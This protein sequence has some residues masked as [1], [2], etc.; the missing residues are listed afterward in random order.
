[1]QEFFLA[2]QPI[3]DRHENLCAF[4]LLFRSGNSAGAGVV[5]DTLA[6]AQVMANAF[7]DVG[8]TEVLGS[9]KGF[10]NLD[11]NF[12]RSDLLELLP[13]EQMVLEL[14]ESIEIDEAII[15][16]C[17]ELKQQGY[18]LALD[19]VID[20]GDEIRPLLDIVDV[21]KLDLTEI[22]AARLPGL[23]RALRQYPVKLLAE[24]VESREQARYCREL[25]F[26]MFQG[27]YFARP[28]TLSGKNIPPS[29]MTLLHVLTLMLGEAGN[30]EIV[31]AFK[32]APDL[33]YG[34]MRMVNSAASGLSM[35]ITSLNQGLMVLGRRQLQRWVQLLI[36]SSEHEKQAVSPLM[37]LAA[38]RGKLME[39]IAR[40]MR[41]GDQ[42]YADRSFMAGILSLLDVLLDVPLPEVLAR[43]N[44]D[45]EIE[46]VLLKRSG[47]MGEMLALCEKLETG[48]VADVRGVL[49]D[50]PGLSADTLNNA[51]LGA[52]AWA[53][54]ITV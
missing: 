2:R 11:A 50:H 27:Y 38:T 37:Q 23:V 35:K 45:E 24:K 52:L 44:M 21:V 33:V 49:G 17:R 10:I 46:A 8:V 26:D 15:Q 51:Q 34:L 20:L 30:E 54:S 39:L 41:P 13:R 42:E 36:Y 18:T 32:S 22:D 29:R 19:D 4:E 40:Q 28:E 1:M 14:L 5:D 6:T 9:C 48:N 31:E 12:L 25:G 43:M 3:V 16:R 47:Q 53:N 7:G